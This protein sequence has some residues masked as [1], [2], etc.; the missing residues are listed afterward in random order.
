M[1]KEITKILNETPIDQQSKKIE[2]LVNKAVQKERERIIE[3]IERARKET[4][5]EHGKKLKPLTNKL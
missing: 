4:E 2:E 5:K 3:M 1:K